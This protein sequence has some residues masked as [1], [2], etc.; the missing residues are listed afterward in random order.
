MRSL[1]LLSAND[2]E[3]I[4]G[5]S[6]AIDHM[7]WGYLY[8][9][10]YPTCGALNRDAPIWARIIEYLVIS[11]TWK[12]LRDIALLEEVCQWKW[13]LEFWILKLGLVSLSFCC[14]LI[15]M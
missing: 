11:A 1:P 9:F 14:L 15:Q 2:M 10:L 12:W 8:D 6:F 4:E 7:I 13:T 5:V 3:A